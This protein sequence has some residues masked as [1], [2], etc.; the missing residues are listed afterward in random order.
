MMTRVGNLLIGFSSESLVSCEQ[1]SDSLSRSWA[2][3]GG[4][5]VKNIQK[6]CFFQRIAGFFRVICSNQERI[7]DVALFKEIKSNILT[8]TIL[9]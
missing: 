7:T 1:K 9:S 8:V 2:E 3:K 5:T 6:I 4:K